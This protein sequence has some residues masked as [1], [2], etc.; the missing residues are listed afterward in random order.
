MTIHEFW[1]K[2]F[3]SF[4][5]EDYKLLVVTTATGLEV[6]VQDLSRVEEDLVMIRGRISGTAD[7]G[8]LFILPY[9][10]LS[11]VYVNRFVRTEEVE[12]FSPNV[13]PERKMEVA[14]SVAEIERRAM[15]EARKAEA[16]K[17]GQPVANDVFKKLESLREEMGDATALPSVA[18]DVAKGLPAPGRG[19]ALP[20]RFARPGLGKDS[21]EKPTG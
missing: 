17:N 7:N 12:L 13:T 18:E 11:N 19:S 9:E 15:D 21:K 5:P 14:R 20:N 2:V 8:R 4:R 3:R 6:A 10:Q 16:V 1:P